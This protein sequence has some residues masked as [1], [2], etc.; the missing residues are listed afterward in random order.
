MPEHSHGLDLTRQHI[1]GWQEHI[2]LPDFDI[3]SMK[4]KIDT[5]ARTSALHAVDLDTFQ[6]GEENWISFHIPRPGVKRNSR[7]E[8]RIA[9]H[10]AIR[11]TSG[12]S[13]T[14]Y[15]IETML[16][17]G[18][19]RWTIEVSLADRE[20]MAFD[21]ILGRTAIRRRRILVAPGKSYLVGAPRLKG[22]QP[23]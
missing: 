15:V 13:E 1:I 7:S 3:A 12:V 4:A 20:E 6:R 16:V 17:L 9:D 22:V 2:A 11:N 8:A 10:R 21:I 14:R 18:R 23:K 19:R 5:G